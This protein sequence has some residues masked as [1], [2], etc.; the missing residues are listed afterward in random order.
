VAR[1]PKCRE[2]GPIDTASALAGVGGNVELLKEAVASGR[3]TFLNS[4]IV[5][6]KIPA[7]APLALAN[8]HIDQALLPAN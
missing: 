2:Q 5:D 3:T 6:S 7:I 8:S 4:C 1:T